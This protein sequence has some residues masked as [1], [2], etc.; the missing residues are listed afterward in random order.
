MSRFINEDELEF[1]DISSEAY[2]EYFHIDYD[3]PWLRIEGPEKLHVS[4]SGGHRII[5]GKFA[6]YVQ[7][8]EAWGIRW[9]VK[10]EQ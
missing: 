4:E 7:P 2:R 6:Y 9:E 3:E 10:D 5:A 8:R 1:Q